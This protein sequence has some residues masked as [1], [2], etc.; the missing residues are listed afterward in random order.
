[1]G[2][3]LKRIKKEICPKS[4]FNS[5]ETME[6][7]LVSKLNSSNFSDTFDVNVSTEAQEPKGENIIFLKMIGKGTF[8]KIYLAQH[9]ITKQLFAI[10]VLSKNNIFDFNEANNYFTEK[11]ILSRIDSP[12][13]IKL[14]FSYR[15]KDSIF[16]ATEFCS[17]GD[18]KSHLSKEKRFVEKKARFYAAEIILALEDLHKFDIIYRDLKPENILLAN[19]GHIKLTDFGLSK[20]LAYG[21]GT[22]AYT[23]CGTNEYLAPEVVIGEGYC[24]DVD[25]WSFGITLYQMLAGKLPFAYEN[26]LTTRLFNITLNF[27]KFMSD[28]AI[29]LIEKLLKVDPME[30]LGYGLIDSREIKEH[31]FFRKVNWSDMKHKKVSP[32]FIPPLEESE[33]LNYFDVSITHQELNINKESDFPH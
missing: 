22:R 27:P 11:G 15:I 32:P 8:G 19:D 12:F 21:E 23:I 25:W 7:G 16:L 24:K 5:L 2:N 14:S 18:L 33:E 4:R 28:A 13:I 29:D 20:W 31:P 10:K 6:L 9:N 26:Q 17:G 3:C 1:M 30:R